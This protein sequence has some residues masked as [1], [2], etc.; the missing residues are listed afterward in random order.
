MF[1]IPEPT[2]FDLRFRL[3]GI[4]VRVHPMFW[5]LSAGLG[6][7]NEGA[8]VVIF[9]LCV[10]VSILVHE[11]GHAL[12]V[13]AEGEIPEVIL[14][15]MGGVCRY[16]REPRSRWRRFR[17]VAA[18]PGFG[19]ILFGLVLGGA[20]LLFRSGTN[21]AIFGQAEVAN[22]YLS[23]AIVNLLYINL[24]WSLFNLLPLLPFDGGQLMQIILECFRPRTQATRWAHVVSLITAGS[25]A[26]YF[27]MKGSIYNS[28]LLAFMAFL[29]FQALQAM[30]YQNRYGDSF[31]DEA[32]WWKR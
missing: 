11:F 6:M 23:F 20:I 16:T 21:E 22:R 32:D 5:V 14:F 19:L 18:G 4:P 24:V 12:M 28:L 1:G 15:W 26:G 27:F 8:E 7:H 10:F 25:I 30:H 13:R 31:E 9:M 17:I 29:N 3:L 2:E